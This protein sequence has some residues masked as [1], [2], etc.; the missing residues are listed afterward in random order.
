MTHEAMAQRPSLRFAEGQAHQTTLEQALQRHASH[1]IFVA[2]ARSQAQIQH[3]QR[4]ALVG[5]GQVS[6]L[7]EHLNQLGALAGRQLRRARGQH[8]LDRS[9][10]SG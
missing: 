6:Q 8:Q 7:T 1:L 10:G 4:C 3:A 5:F 2:E 9:I